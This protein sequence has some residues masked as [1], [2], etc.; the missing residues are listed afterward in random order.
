VFGAGGAGFVRINYATSPAIL[1]DAVHRMGA[2]AAT[3]TR[4]R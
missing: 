4:Q 1:R 3:A 2:A